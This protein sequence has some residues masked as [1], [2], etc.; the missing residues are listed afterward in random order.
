MLSGA[1]AK[2]CIECMKKKKTLNKTE[3]MTINIT[4]RTQ[5]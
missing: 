2:P 4:E 5:H 1:P 3:I